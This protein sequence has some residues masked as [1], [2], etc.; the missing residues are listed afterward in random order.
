MAAVSY[1]HLDVYKR[2]ALGSEFGTVT[3]ESLPSIFGGNVAKADAED[4]SKVL[5]AAKQAAAD[6]QAKLE[7]AQKRCV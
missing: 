2:Q 5:D 7:A 1:T 4:K 6:A 3:P